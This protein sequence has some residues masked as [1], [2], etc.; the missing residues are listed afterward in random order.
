MAGGLHPV[1][2]RQVVLAND[3]RDQQRVDQDPHAEPEQQDEADADDREDGA[4]QQQSKL[5]GAAAGLAEVEAVSSEHAEEEPQEIADLQLL[6]VGLILHL[7]PVLASIVIF[8]S[9][10]NSVSMTVHKKGRIHR[11]SGCGLL[12]HSF[13]QDVGLAPELVPWRKQVGR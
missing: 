2:E 4:K 6:A 12:F 10:K 1:D 13:R 11:K 8:R 7:A 5:G 9:L 3:A